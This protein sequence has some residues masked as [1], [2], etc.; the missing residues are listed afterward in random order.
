MTIPTPYLLAAGLSAVVAGW[1]L[2]GD[3]VTGGRED[4][5]PETVSE[6]N[7]KA[8][9]TLFKVQTNVFEAEPRIALIEARGSTEASGKVSVRAETTGLLLKRHVGKGDA[10]KVG[11][12]ICSLKTGDRE[13]RVAQSAAELKRAQVELDA[14]RKLVTN[15]YATQYRVVENSATLDAAIAQMKAAEI[16]LGRIEIRS[17][18]AGLVQDPFAKVGDMLQVGD[19]CANVMD[20][21]SIIMTAQVSERYIGRMAIGSK[22]KVRVVTGEQVEGAI[23]FI[24]PSADTETRTFRIEIALP[25]DETKIRDGVTAVASIVLPGDTSHLLPASVLTLNDAGEI[26]VKMVQTPN[27]VAFTPVKILEDTRDGVWVSGLPSSANLI[28][29]GHEYV[30][31]GQKV[32]PVTK[33]AEIN[34]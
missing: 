14:A 20:P 19:I 7:Q 4:A 2:S 8:E 12:L 21:Q 5:T 26:G 1:M 11:D 34:Q 18:V 23:Q 16:E 10:V 3:I 33:T 13:A 30:T 9:Q 27:I 22:A 6:R 17:P 31:N 28:I 15:G 32:D 29:R 25:N 24:A